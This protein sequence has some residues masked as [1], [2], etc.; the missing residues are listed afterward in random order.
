MNAVLLFSFMI[1]HTESEFTLTKGKLFVIEKII[2]E[3]SYVLVVKNL[4]LKYNRLLQNK[5]NDGQWF[6]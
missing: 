6:V 2:D 5:K 1:L 3:M 4:Y